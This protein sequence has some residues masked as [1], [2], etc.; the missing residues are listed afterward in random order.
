MVLGQPIRR[1]VVHISSWVMTG[2]A[3]RGLTK[4]GM[5]RWIRWDPTRSGNT[6]AATRGRPAFGTNVGRAGQGRADASRVTE[7]CGAHPWEGRCLG[8]PIYQ[9]AGWHLNGLPTEDRGRNMPRGTS[10]WRA[11]GTRHLVSSRPTV[12]VDTGEV[13]QLADWC[14]DARPIVA[15]AKCYHVALTDDGG[16]DFREGKQGFWARGAGGGLSRHN[17]LVRV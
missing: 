7:E 9:I 5:G 6:V 10:Q 16:V 17:Q 8:K 4:R 3:T 12:V 14:R 13:N 15:V 11:G 2:S 1:R